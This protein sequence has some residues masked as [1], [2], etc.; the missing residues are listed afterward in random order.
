MGT[1]ARVVLLIGSGRDA[2]LFQGCNEMEGRDSGARDTSV[3]ERWREVARH[4]PYGSALMREEAV[5][6]VTW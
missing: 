2:V 1:P 4:P 6:G 3:A 5:A